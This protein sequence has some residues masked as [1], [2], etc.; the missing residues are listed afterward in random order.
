MPT[1]RHVKDALHKSIEAHRQA[2]RDHLEQAGLAEHTDA[3]VS[4][5]GPLGD[6][7]AGDGSQDG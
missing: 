3:T 1:H 5:L 2:H 6:M 7:G 4:P